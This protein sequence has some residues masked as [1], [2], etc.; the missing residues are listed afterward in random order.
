MAI[1][2]AKGRL[3]GKPPKLTVRQRTHM[4]A[5]HQAGQHTVAELAELFSVSRATVY[6]ELARGARPV[7][8]GTAP[9]C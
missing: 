2:R 1:A 9:S 6:R 7:S 4:L 8:V 3:R 5:Q